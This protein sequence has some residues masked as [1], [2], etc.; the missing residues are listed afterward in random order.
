MLWRPY[1]SH[2]SFFLIMLGLVGTLYGLLI[3]LESSGVEAVAGEMSAGAVRV[4]V[5]RLL[6]GTATAVLSSLVGIVGAF[7]AA[8]PMAWL[9]CL[10]LPEGVQEEIEDSLEDTVLRITEGLG[11]MDH[12]VRTLTGSLHP[13]PLLSLVEGI[14]RLQETQ[15]VLSDRVQRLTEQV[16]KQEAFSAL[17]NLVTL[18]Q[19]LLDKISEGNSARSETLTL[20]KQLVLVAEKSLQTQ[21]E[22]ALSRQQ[23]EERAV[24]HLKL[25]EVL[26][27][28]VRELAA[29]QQ[30]AARINK[31]SIEN[32]ADLLRELDASRGKDRQ[33][34]RKRFLS[35]LAEMESDG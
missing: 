2:F 34:M 24:Q 23:L 31:E 29:S 19:S 7:V 3:G 21:G 11:R 1:P 4:A 8:R 26:T 6:S 5:D 32:L 15:Q 27:G 17:T 10:L 25:G 9:Y 13:I 16:P 33:A 28:I 35:L 14:N 30:Q 18:Q 12:A 20:L 22:A